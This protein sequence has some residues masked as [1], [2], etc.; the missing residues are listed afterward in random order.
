M[1]APYVLAE[2]F[3]TKATESQ[4]IAANLPENYMIGERW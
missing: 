2:V 4:D 3:G 1:A